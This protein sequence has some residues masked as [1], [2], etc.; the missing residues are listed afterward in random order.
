[1]SYQTTNLECSSARKLR[2]ALVAVVASVSFCT[3]AQTVDRSASIAPGLDEIIVTGH[4]ER[5]LILDA[6]TDTGSRLGMTAREVPAIVDILSERQMR[7]LGARTSL[8]A[9]NRAPGV[10]ASLTATSPGIP[11]MRGFT[12]VGLLYDGVRVGTPAMVARTIDSWAFERVEILKGPASVLY[13]EGALGGAINLIPKRPDLD[14]RSAQGLVS[15][16]SFESARAAADVNM[17][18]SDVFAVR[19]VGSYSQSD[20]YV[21][22]AGNEFLGGSL[23][24]RYTPTERLSVDL[25]FDYNE[26]SYDVADLGTPLVPRSVAQDPSNAVSSADGWVVD[27]GRRENNYNFRD[28]IIDSDTQ[29]YRSHINY[30]LAEGLAINNQ[31]TYYH[32]DRNF[33]N[34]EIFNYNLDTGLLDRS[35]GIVT[36]DLDFLI[37]RLALTADFHLGGMR[38]RVAVGGEYSDLDFATRRYFV[39]GDPGLSVTLD[40]PDRGR[41]PGGFGSGESLPPENQVAD[42]AIKSLFAEYALDLTPRWLLAA[43]LRSDWIELER[44]LL[45]PGTDYDRDYDAVSWRAGTVYDLLPKTQLFAQYSEAIAPVSNFLLMSL[46]NSTFELT[47]GQSVEGGIKSSLWDDRLD[48]TVSAYWIEQDNIITRDPQDPTLRVQG[49]RTSSRGIEVSLSAAITDSLRIDGNYTILDVRFEELLDAE[50]ESLKGNTPPRVPQTVA[51]LFAFYSVPGTRFTLSG[52]IRHAGHFY[53]DEANSIRIN[54]YTTID[55]AIGYEFPFGELTLRGRN[56]TDEFYVD[57]T[58]VN[59]RQFQIAAPRSVDV[60]FSTGF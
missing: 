6:K 51:N 4:A 49:G 47:E 19:A 36:H 16:G 8:E 12:T 11:T 23:S 24:A 10:T 52:G 54:S 60:T 5:Q 34:A 30:E 25:A 3:I 39:F 20:G 50:G 44:S 21:D 58:D 33:I 59:A 43:G 26:D 15:Y 1:M 46:S 38:N 14:D 29:W 35:S 57:Y 42:V 17:P 2:P 9:L 56:L 32:S 45:E 37:E 55:A 31:L 22:D 13:G 48:A 27:R 53:T 18:L 28:G 7:E 41:F 40:D